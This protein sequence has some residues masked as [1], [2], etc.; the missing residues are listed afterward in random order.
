MYTSIPT[1]LFSNVTVKADYNSS[2]YPVN[3]TTDGDNGQEGGA[4]TYLFYL[5]SVAVPILFGSITLIGVVGNSLVIYVIITKEKLRTTTNLMLLNLAIADI[6]FLVSCAPFT[7]YYFATQHWPFGDILCRLMHYLL[8]VTAYV[9]VY[10]LVGISV[11][12]FFIIV[13]TVE[14]SR[15]RTK[16]NIILL[17]FT[18]WLVM[19]TLNVPIWFTH[20]AQP[21]GYGNVACYNFG[22]KIGQELYVT[23][24]VFAFLLPLI[25]IS[26]VYLLIL[27]F[28]RRQKSATSA[29]NSNRSSNRKKH[30]TRMIII[31][32]IIFGISW[33]PLHV[34]LLVAYFGQISQSS[35]YQTVSVFWNG[36]AYTNSCINPII[37]NYASRDFRESFREAICCACQE[38]RQ[39]A[40]LR[41][42]NNTSPL[43]DTTYLNY[44]ENGC[45]RVTTRK[46]NH[47][48][49][50][51]C[52]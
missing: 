49:N 31:V 15:L 36:L 2:E 47:G 13:Y 25:A 6:S 50:E 21:D 45:V 39:R 34:H 35:F 32:I 8:N 4:S 5:Y 43:L 14:T 29:G 10:T 51:N 48:D 37:Y 12:R 11:L 38:K 7:A 30:A 42:G 1:A 23:F 27:H 9:T 41:T 44:T 19:L 24:F 52:V 33:L 16:Q 22:V 20:G 17:A 40:P 26:V 3:T 18:I 28:I 46:E